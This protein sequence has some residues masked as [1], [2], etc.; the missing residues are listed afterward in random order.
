MLNSV[1]SRVP[2]QQCRKALPALNWPYFAARW[3]PNY[4]VKQNATVSN[5]GFSL[6]LPVIMIKFKYAN[7]FEWL[8]PPIHKKKLY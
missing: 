4:N 2:K 7:D 8:H 3:K 1:K 6:K 5:G